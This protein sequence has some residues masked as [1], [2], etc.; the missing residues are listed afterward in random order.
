[1]TDQGIGIPREILPRLFEKFYR[2]H[3]STMPAVCGTGLG[4]HICKQIVDAHGGQIWVESEPDKG[5]TFSFTIPFASKPAGNR[6][7]DLGRQVP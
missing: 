2:G 4:L 1:V 7:N 6:G 3:S 5:A